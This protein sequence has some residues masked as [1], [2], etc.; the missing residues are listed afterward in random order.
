MN[1]LQYFSQTADW[2]AACSCFA[3][4]KLHHQHRK[5]TWTCISIPPTKCAWNIRKKQLSWLH[6]L[7]FC[8]KSALLGTHWTSA[9]FELRGKSY[10]DSNA[11]FHKLL[12]KQCRHSAS[13]FPATDINRSHTQTGM[14]AKWRHKPHVC[15]ECFT[16]GP[17]SSLC[18]FYSFL[19]PSS[20][21]SS[22]H[23]SSS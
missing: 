17:P 11:V 18:Y 1:K 15:T 6:V 19:R 13:Y 2:S 4:I 8:Q 16:A 7:P 20:L 9:T 14:N 12:A 5:K 10:Q 3:L 21:C 22:A 23:I